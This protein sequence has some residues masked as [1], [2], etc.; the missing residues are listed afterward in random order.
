[1]LSLNVPNP[2]KVES[3]RELPGAP[4]WPYRAFVSG[5]CGSG[6]RSATMSIV[7]GTCCNVWPTS[8]VVIHADATGSGPRE[9]GFADRIIGLE[10]LEEFALGESVESE[11]DSEGERLASWFPL[12]VEDEFGQ[13]ERYLVVIDEIPWKTLNKRLVSCFERL[14]NFISTHRNTS[15]ICQAQRYMSVPPEIRNAFNWLVFTG[16]R[17]IA[18]GTERADVAKRIGIPSEDLTAIL[19]L[20]TDP[21]SILSCDMTETDPVARWRLGF[22]SPVRVRQ[23]VDG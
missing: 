1:M 20:A 2:D 3:R 9:Y 10:D 22:V 12:P 8:I 17:A 11:N 21:F 18:N 19:G 23:R 13:A 16:D 4:Q 6:K 15:V 7:A 5:Q 14:V